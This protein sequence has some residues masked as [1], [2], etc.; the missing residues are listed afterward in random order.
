MLHFYIL[1]ILRLFSMSLLY[2]NLSRLITIMFIFVQ[3]VIFF[4]FYLML[5]LF[6]FLLTVSGLN[7]PFCS[8]KIK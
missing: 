8:N 5:I 1:C 7:G 3:I 6:K 2:F 4:Y